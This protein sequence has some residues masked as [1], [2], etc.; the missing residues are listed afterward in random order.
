MTTSSTLNN[1]LGGVT[2]TI[3]RAASVGDAR[4]LEFSAFIDTTE[5]NGEALDEVG[6]VN[7]PTDKRLYN[8]ATINTVN[9]TNQKTV[10]V[11]GTLKFRS[12]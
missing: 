5:F 7:N 2:L 12:A 1:E 4:D 11:D 9:K 3:V 8:H 6:V 10:T